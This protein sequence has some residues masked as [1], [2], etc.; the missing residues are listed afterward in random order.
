L[1][2]RQTPNIYTEKIEKKWMFG[3][4]KHVRTACIARRGHAENWRGPGGF[5][6][7]PPYFV[8]AGL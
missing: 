2:R 1:P 8:S 3:I 7:E 4:G 5:A 6:A